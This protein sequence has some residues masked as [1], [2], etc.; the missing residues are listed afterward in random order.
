MDG[1]EEVRRA[2]VLV[3]IVARR[4]ELQSVAL[5]PEVKDRLER[6]VALVGT[7]HQAARNET[8]IS[9]APFARRPRVCVWVTV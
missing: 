4:R 1:G 7:R 6:R 3:K 9:F 5:I 8:I 2:P